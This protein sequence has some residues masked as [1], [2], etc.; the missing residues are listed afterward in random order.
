MKKKSTGEAEQEIEASAAQG[1]NSSVEQEVDVLV[2]E[3]K[4]FAKK[5]TEN[6]LG[7]AR[8]II[9]VEDELGARARL[10]FYEKVGLDPNGSTVRKL[11]A[12]GNKLPRF[13]PYL[14]VLPNTWT[15]LY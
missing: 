8:T 9:K 11:I 14:D 4:T 13:Q 3:Y 15:T 6:V 12:I 10:R 2:R 1:P 7:L 5:S